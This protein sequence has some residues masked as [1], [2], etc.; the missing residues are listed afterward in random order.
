MRFLLT[1]LVAAAVS[2]VA[3][4][5]LSPH[6]QA[7]AQLESATAER[8][9]ADA[10]Q[11]F[12]DRLY[13]EAVHGFTS[14]L[15]TY[16][17][18]VN[19][20]DALYYQAE[21]SLALG[22]DEEAVALFRRLEDR[23]P[24]HPL[25]AQ[26]RLA[27]GNF[28][29]SSDQHDRAIEV[30]SEVLDDEPGP[31]A[32]AEALY[33]MG[34]SAL[35]LNREDEAI[36]Y[37]RRAADTYRNTDTAPVA[38]YSIGYTQVRQERYDAAA[39]AFEL[40]A[41]RYP[42]SSYAR[43]IGLALAEVYYELSDYQRVIDETERRMGTLGEDA[44]ERAL[45]LQA[46]SYNHLRN[47]EQAIVHYRRFI[48][49]NPDSPYY[50]L[51]LYGLG[52]NY[53]YE[54]VHQWAVDQFAAVRQGHGDDLAAR[55]TYYE[56]V[57]RT[58][59]Q[60]QGAA[61][62]LLETFVDRWPDHEL[63]PYA[64][65]ELGLG[66]Y[67]QRRWE[68]AHTALSRVIED[69]P[70]SDLIGE[71]LYYRANAAVARGDFADALTNFDRAADL[72]AAPPRL[73]EEVRFQRAWLQYRSEN[74]APALEGFMEI[75]DEAP[76]S[77]RGQESLFWA[78]ESQ[79][80]LGNLT[81]AAELF[82]TYVRDVPGGEHVDA[83]HYALGWTHFRR[84]QYGPAVRE[85][86][87][88]L[89][90]YQSTGSNEFVPYRTDAL[91][92]LADSYYALKQYAQAIQTYRRVIDQ[93]GDYA[94]YQI[95]QAFYNSGDA[96]EAVNAYRELL[97]FYSSSQWTEE[98][99]YNLGY[100][101]FQNQD[102]DQAIEEY[103][104]LIGNH[105]RDPLA[106]RAQYGIG[107]ALFNAGRPEEAIEAYQVVLERYSS[108]PYVAD[109]AAGVQYALLSIG[110]QE[111]ADEL[112]EQFIAENPNSP[113]V[114]ELRFRRAEVYYQSGS[115]EEALRELQQFVRTSGNEELLPEAYYYIGTI[116]DDRQQDEEAAS[117]F[118]QIVDNFAG[119]GRFPDAARRLGRIYANNDQ[120]R[121]ALE[122][123]ETLESDADG[124]NRLIAEARYGQGMA[125]LQLGRREEAERLLEEAI[126]AAPDAP[127]TYPAYLGLARV[128]EEAGR[129][130]EALQL[131]RQVVRNSRDE[132]GAE[133]LYH[134]GRLLRMTGSPRQAVDELGRMPVLFTGFT[135]WVARGYLEQAR[136]F[137][138]LGQAGDAVQMYDRV[139]QEFADTPYALSAE[140]EKEAL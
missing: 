51:A 131:Y 101:F 65:F 29:Y 89:S 19:A 118:R 41:A 61:I 107:D 92:R 108:S 47:S 12:A 67:E 140:Q 100:V 30:L 133:A 81:R 8:S 134:L 36:S 121:A 114:D 34:E 96:Y 17:D 109:A 95:A 13:R 9:F 110:D 23:F 71:A 112:I 25:A 75:Y 85:F 104:T 93:A 44:R 26:S 53:Y 40:L 76:R 48:D 97:E 15:R 80:Q 58:L 82:T 50:R 88:F 72:G 31:E 98:A 128:R 119:S 122:V 63:A 3:M 124:D 91:L 137:R 62:E 27:L 73:R 42:E 60:E 10:Y 43:N 35:N 99:R 84:S 18:H 90:E 86:Q 105:P 1:A 11:L 69:F 46:E 127:E 136:S 52:W 59:S 39:Q 66:Y 6:M 74:Y 111:R 139:I 5:S 132:I 24:Q 2:C 135:E 126:D 22:F 14:F 87:T 94:L 129:H 70:D 33:W 57:N 16:P 4:P 38:L 120:P 123:F 138:A 79:Y 117:Y 83:A 54:G 103:E 7:T 20:A 116:F 130:D 113:I 45:F 77:D 55:A 21:A 28:F 56:A 78:A 115:S 106:A 102:Y 64:R 125:L 32:S 37:F 68:D 49:G